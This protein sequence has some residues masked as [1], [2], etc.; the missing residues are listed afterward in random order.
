MLSRKLKRKQM[1]S[2]YLKTNKPKL[3][4]KILPPISTSP[5]P[6]WKLHVDTENTSHF[7]KEESLSKKNED[8]ISKFIMYEEV[9]L[10]KTEIKDEHYMIE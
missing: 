4:K 8:N 5:G 9:V 6:I 7:S 3:E 10:K 1:I 2:V